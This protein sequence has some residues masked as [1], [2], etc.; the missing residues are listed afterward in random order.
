MK[1]GTARRRSR[2][3]KLGTVS[4]RL[5]GLGV[6][7]SRGD[8]TVSIRVARLRGCEVA[9]WAGPRDLATPRPRN[10]ASQFRPELI[11]RSLAKVDRLSLGQQ[12]VLLH[13]IVNQ[14]RHGLA[15]GADHVRD[16]LM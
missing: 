16:R 5:R 13:Q 10:P 2:V 7:R 9:G 12:Q 4:M 14:P 1:T 3:R 8:G 11:Q 6:A 15:R